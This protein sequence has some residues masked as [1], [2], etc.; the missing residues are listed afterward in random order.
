METRS[1]LFPLIK[2]LCAYFVLIV[3]IG[4]VMVPEPYLLFVL[5]FLATTFM[6]LSQI[7][8][9]FVPVTVTPFET[10]FWLHLVTE[11]PFEPAVADKSDKRSGDA[12]RVTYVSL[13]IFYF[14]FIL[15]GFFRL[16]GLLFQKTA[17]DGRRHNP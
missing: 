2:S 6:I 5:L 1:W 9:L 13:L 14:F 4:C 16:Y 3:C 15:L 7:L 17:R 10:P 8:H 11:S 12:W